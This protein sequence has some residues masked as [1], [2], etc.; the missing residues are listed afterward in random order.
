[1]AQVQ[2][3]AKATS[4]NRVLNTSFDQEFQT[5][6]QQPM[7]YD[8]TN[9]QRMNADNMA[10]KITVSGSITYVAVAAPG[11]AQSIAKWQ[12]KKIDETTGTVITWADGNANFDNVATDLT[13]LTYS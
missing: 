11:T 10:T 2:D 6:V 12:C 1:M 7:G 9:I 5:L 8:G 13:L 3:P 4:P